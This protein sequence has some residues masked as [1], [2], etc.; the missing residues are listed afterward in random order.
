MNLNP[1]D[2]RTSDSFLRESASLAYLPLINASSSK[3]ANLTSQ[4]VTY[5]LDCKRYDAWGPSMLVVDSFRYL[6]N[7]A[8]LTIGFGDFFLDFSTENPKIKK[9]T[10]SYFRE[11]LNTEES[12]YF[13]RLMQYLGFQRNAR[14]ILL[15]L[16]S[17][18]MKPEYEVWI[19][20]LL[21]QI[22]RTISLNEWSASKLESILKTHSTAISPKLRFNATL[23]IA[24]YYCTSAG[25]NQVS[26]QKWLDDANSIIRSDGYFKKN[27]FDRLIAELRLARYVAVHLLNQ[28]QSKAYHEVVSST[29]TKIN[30]KI[31]D[32]KMNR[33]RSKLFLL[34]EAKRR[35]LEYHVL[36]LC[37][38]QR[39]KKAIPFAI[40]AVSVD[41]HCAKALMI[42]G[43]VLFQGNNKK[44]AVPYYRQA[45]VKGVLENS[46]CREMLV[47]LKVLPRDFVTQDPLMIE[48]CS[49]D[50]ERNNEVDSEH[51]LFDPSLT[52]VSAST[53]PVF[54]TSFKPFL[55]KFENKERCAREWIKSTEAYQQ[56]LPFWELRESG[57]VGPILNQA[58][59]VAWEALRA[60]KAPFFETLYIQRIMMPEFRNELVNA[61]IR[62][63]TLAQR[64]LKS[65]TKLSFLDNLSVRTTQLLKSVDDIN[66]TS[67]LEKN[68]I[69]RVVGNLG[70]IRDAFDISRDNSFQQ[71]SIWTVEESYLN[72]TFLFY[73]FILERS[74]AVDLG[75]KLEEAMLKTPK[76]ASTLRARFS[77]CIIACVYYGQ[78]F[79]HAQLVVWRE[80]A[81]K[82]MDEINSCASF[83]EFEKQLL[84]SRYYRAVCY[85]PFCTG[86]EK[87]LL[88]DVQKCESFSRALHPKNKHQKI[89]K[90]D[91]LYSM[92]DTLHRIYLKLNDSERAEKML[93]EILTDID[94]VDSKALNQLGELY[95]NQGRIDEAIT[96]FRKATIYGAPQGRIAAF[97]AGYLLEGKEDYGLAQEYYFLSLQFWP[98]GIS[99]L[100][101]L[102]RIAKKTQ[103]LYLKKWTRSEIRKYE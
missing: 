54:I 19:E 48:I 37:E 25:L 12:I 8:G 30:S 56:F 87:Q 73:K 20:L 101:G 53:G 75:E 103:D 83:S 76:T 94:P 59:L 9:L 21:T 45:L 31:K 27:P 78:A 11:N 1:N 62:H 100:T 28:G 67:I 64:A 4:A 80:I 32:S 79:N 14:T 71:K 81:R 89:L 23:M 16:R 6:L 50:R 5:W 97:R 38:L 98:K 10:E 57:T 40:E 51:S 70:F 13:A 55:K 96:C 3:F 42:A 63:T 90:R 35:L 72:N 95:E 17:A 36:N 85:L 24:C 77:N 84:N 99:P 26:A 92:L 102:S 65:A 69:A 43:D 66:R 47:K 58:P 29:L 2:N 46:Y 82:T 49:T 86:D 91:N 52:K 68:M 7:Q 34:K 88:D 18:Q 41:P 74:N 44:K 22:D 61:S 60:K 15:A 39:F 33:N 93:Q